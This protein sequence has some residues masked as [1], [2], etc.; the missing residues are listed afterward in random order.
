MA[1]APPDADPEKFIIGFTTHNGR[2]PG[3]CTNLRVSRPYHD[4]DVFRI[5]PI[6]TPVW[7][8]LFVNLIFIAVCYGFHWALKNFTH[9]TAP[10]WAVYGIP[11]GI[12]A[13]TCGTVTAVVYWTVAQA[14]RLGPW[15]IY[16]KAT[17]RVELP[18]LGVTF[19]RQQIVHLQSISTKQLDRD[20]I[21]N[22]PRFSE[23]NLVTSRDGIRERWPLLRSSLDLETYDYI[24]KSLLEN[25]D[26]PVVRV[27]DELL[28]WH[29]TETPRTR[30][31]APQ[32]SSTDAPPRH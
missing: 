12:G 20:S 5:D 27:Q 18:R 15:L 28:G 29:V 23:L 9:N 19:D 32:P 21:L 16:D 11:V 7:S 30:S 3:P 8:V 14:Q 25:T 22:N 26:L 10:P 4:T 31:A 13:I 24:L 6:P 17:G 2:N 1:K